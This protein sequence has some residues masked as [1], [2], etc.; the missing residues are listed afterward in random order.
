[1]TA[2][3]HAG[4]DRPPPSPAARR[5]ALWMMVA[6]VFNWGYAWLV[7]KVALSFATPFVLATL[8]I[9]VAVAA[10]FAALVWAGRVLRPRSLKGCVVVGLLQTALFLLLNNWALAGGSTGSISILVFTMPFWVL[11]FAWWGLGERIAP[12]GWVSVGLAAVGLVA[13]MELPMKSAGLFSKLLAVGAGVAWGLGAVLAKRLHREVEL[14][15]LNFTFWQMVFGLIPMVLLVVVSDWPPIQWT[16]TF[17][18]CVL[19]L[20]IVATAVGWWQWFYVLR[21]LPAGV[22]GMSSLGVPVVAVLG[23]F[24]HFGERPSAMEALGTVLVLCAIALLC[25]DGWRRV[26]R[27]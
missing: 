1:M 5:A 10:M 21:A 19:L 13:L 14:D 6:L 4:A 24:V 25:F 8:R 7:S 18:A 27:A 15:L 26:R 22:T 23:A 9:A 2:P 11:L 12:L 17:I 20:G 16:P 3:S